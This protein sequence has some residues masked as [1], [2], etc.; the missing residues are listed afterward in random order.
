VQA[1]EPLYDISREQI[2][3]KWLSRFDESIL[4]E[5][6]NS[7]H[8]VKLFDGCEVEARGTV[9]W[10]YDP[11]TQVKAPLIYGKDI[12]YRDNSLV[13]N[14]K[15]IWEFARHKHLVSYAEMYAITGDE[16]FADKIVAH[17][18]SW[19]EQ[20]PYGLGVHWCSSL[21]V[22][23][24]VIAWSFCHHIMRTRDPKG[25]Q[26]RCADPEKFGVSVFQ[27]VYFIVHYL[28]RYSSANNHLI[29]ELA[30]VWIACKLFDL[31]D[32]GEKWSMQAKRELEA[33]ARK[34]VYSDGVSKEQAAYYHLWVLEY[35]LTVWVVGERY[36]DRFSGEFSLT[37][38]KMNDFIKSIRPMRGKVP[39]IGDSDDGMVLSFDQFMQSD[40]YEELTQTVDAFKATSVEAACGKSRKAFWL[41]QALTKNGK[42]L[43]TLPSTDDQRNRLR[44]YPEGG[45][46]VIADDP[47]HLVFDAGSLG[48]PSI[49]AHGHA[50]ALSVCIAWKGVWWLVDPGTYCYHTQPVWRDYFRSTG[51]H[52]TVCVNGLDQSRIGGAFLWLKH[53]NARLEKLDDDGSGELVL[54]GAVEGYSKETGVHRRRVVY[55]SEEKTVEVQDKIE[56]LVHGE[57]EVRFHFHPS[58]QCQQTD[59]TTCVAAHSD[60]GEFVTINLDNNLTWA[61]RRGETNPPLGWYSEALGKKEPCDVI[62]GVG[63]LE[64]TSEC[65]TRFAWPV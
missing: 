53:S 4:R 40:P 33:E 37:I 1:S 26:M 50:D 17:V 49:A 63:R 22:S 19:I 34:Q 39:Q 28:S 65:K 29:G 8:V 47:L 48:Y 36:G 5:A 42:L 27:H 21:E 11:D 13:G 44:L 45:Y 35:L 23:L 20:N 64:K 18:D 51:A 10:H 2:R 12:D 58:I 57:F 3:K 55:L 60:T 61:V 9:D 14:C 7:L 62:V 56:N 31:G 16:I 32:S 30:G 52:N 43:S 24:R 54:T 25:L 38:S 59:S 41:E 46:A 6:K 15:T